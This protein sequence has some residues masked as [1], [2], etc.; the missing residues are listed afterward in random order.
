MQKTGSN[1][2]DIQVEDCLESNSSHKFERA[3]LIGGN[4]DPC[5]VLTK[6]NGTSTLGAIDLA[7]ASATISAVSEQTANIPA[8]APL[9]ASTTPMSLAQG[10]SGEAV[11]QVLDVPQSEYFL[12][13]S[14]ANLRFYNKSECFKKVF[15]TASAE[16]ERRDEF[17]S[18][19]IRLLVASPAYI[20]GIGIKALLYWKLP[21]VSTAIGTD[22]KVFSMSDFQDETG[23]IGNISE[24]TSFIDTDK[25]VI[26]NNNPSTCLFQV[27]LACTSKNNNNNNNNNNNE[28]NTFF[29]SFL[30][31]FSVVFVFMYYF[32]MCVCIFIRFV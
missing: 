27:N 31:L 8:G 22:F 32:C 6:Y 2:L 25:L 17:N 23:Q 26:I 21:V 13:M 30:V 12:V 7:A 9:V 10:K 18:V 11:T 28:L 1:Q 15:D 24:F 19:G 14:G 5:F 16:F 29:F 20:V 3:L 4:P